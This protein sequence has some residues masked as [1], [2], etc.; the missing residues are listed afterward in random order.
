MFIASKAPP[1]S[2]SYISLYDFPSQ[3]NKTYV[4]RRKRIV[5]SEPFIKFDKRLKY[6]SF[7][8]FFHNSYN[9]LQIIFFEFKNTPSACA[10]SVFHY[11]FV[12]KVLA[13]G[14]VVFYQFRICQKKDRKDMEN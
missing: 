4:C 12:G 10:K 14:M 6:K 3:K 8:T 9:T 2:N 13:V 11:N 5:V 7:G 1:F